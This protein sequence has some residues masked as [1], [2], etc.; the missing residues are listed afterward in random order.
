MF[1]CVNMVT[2]HKLNVHHI[3]YYVLHTPHQGLAA[4][5]TAC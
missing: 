2:I 4:F 3:G 5:G 1:I